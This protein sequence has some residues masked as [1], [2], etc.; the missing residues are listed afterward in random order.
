MSQ[1][2]PTVGVSSTH[3]KTMPAE[4]AALPVWNAEN[5]FYE[6][7]QVGHKIRSLRRTMSEGESMQF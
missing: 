1:F 5:W 7:W 4:H 3:P 2:S 6:D